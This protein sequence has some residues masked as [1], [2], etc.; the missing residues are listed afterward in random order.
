MDIMTDTNEG[1]L[2]EIL[3]AALAQQ[4]AAHE[5]D[6][7]TSTELAE[8]LGCSGTTAARKLKRLLAEGVVLPAKV[9]RV[10]L[11]GAEQVVCGYRLAR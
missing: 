10:N 11:W 9:R 6:T 8:H 5:R 1:A 2:L 4:D 7:I 3:R